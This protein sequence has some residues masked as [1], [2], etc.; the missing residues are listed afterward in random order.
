MWA[1]DVQAAK[2][3]GKMIQ[4]EMAQGKQDARSQQEEDS[5]WAAMKKK[6]GVDAAIAETVEALLD[7]GFGWALQEERQRRIDFHKKLKALEEERQ[8]RDGGAPLKE[9]WQVG[10]NRLMYRDRQR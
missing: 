1:A 5:R 3:E 10:K 6:E 4:E 7:R 8:A 2:K 9:G